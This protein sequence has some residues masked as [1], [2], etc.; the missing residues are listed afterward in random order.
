MI[1]GNHAI[2]AVVHSDISLSTYKQHRTDTLHI[3]AQFETPATC[4][5]TQHDSSWVQ[6]TCWPLL[7]QFWHEGDYMVLRTSHF[8]SLSYSSPLPHQPIM[9]T[10]R[11]QPGESGS[12]SSWLVGTTST[13]SLIGTQQQLR[14]QLV[15][16]DTANATTK[17]MTRDPHLK[18]VRQTGRSKNQKQRAL[19]CENIHIEVNGHQL[20]IDHTAGVCRD[21]HDQFIAACNG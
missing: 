3:A 21:L 12:K 9:D 7:I 8:F 19:G 16:R 10:Q 6:P 14:H 18:I 5:H 4:S 11:P 13:M 15:P 20:T 1:S 17:H 2:E